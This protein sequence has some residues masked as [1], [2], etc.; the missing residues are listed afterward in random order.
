MIKTLLTILILS[1]SAFAQL[2]VSAPVTGEHLPSTFTIPIVVEHADGIIAY[3][4]NLSYNEDVINPTGT[5]YGCSVADTLASEMTAVCN[6]YPE[7]TLRVVVYGAYSISG[8]GPILNVTFTT[9][10]LA[11]DH[12]STSLWFS[13]L[14]LFNQQGRV[15]SSSNSGEITLRSTIDQFPVD[16]E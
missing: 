2:T 7:G 13:N 1:I 5:N 12:D 10:S 15:P 6:I 3:Q 9:Y 14:Y 8:S 16:D 4:F 11:A